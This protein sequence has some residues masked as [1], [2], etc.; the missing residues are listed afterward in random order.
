MIGDDRYTVSWISRIGHVR[1]SISKE[2]QQEGKIVSSPK[3]FVLDITVVKECPWI[4]RFRGE[5]LLRAPMKGII[6]WWV[7][8]RRKDFHHQTKFSPTQPSLNFSFLA[9]ILMSFSIITICTVWTQVNSYDN[10]HE[11]PFCSFG[12]GSQILAE[13]FSINDN[14]FQMC[15]GHHQQWRIFANQVICCQLDGFICSSNHQLVH[16]SQN[17]RCKNKTR[18]LGKLGMPEGW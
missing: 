3:C 17:Y 18:L 10:D 12:C 8:R 5:E 14:R 13:K 9:M 6:T 1:K 2:V 11:V 16:A 7:R 15:C 4:L